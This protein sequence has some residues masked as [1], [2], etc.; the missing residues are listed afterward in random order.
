M[1]YECCWALHCTIGKIDLVEIEYLLVQRANAKYHFRKFNGFPIIHA[2][3]CEEI[4]KIS[5][6]LAW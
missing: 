5:L 3:E 1:L 2:I 4:E 6:L